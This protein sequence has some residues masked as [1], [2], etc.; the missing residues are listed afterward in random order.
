MT[1]DSGEVR[2]R[3][4][5]RRVTAVVVTHMR[6]RLAGDLVRSLIEVED[7]P[8]H[9]IIVV[10]NAVGGLDDPDLEESVRMLRLSTN[11]G[12]AGGF[13]AGMEEAFRDPTTLLAQAL[14]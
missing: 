3:A 14:R 9:R 13:K 4:T 5:D 7:L 10:V 12:P 8:A 11:E 1:S 6:P 2:A